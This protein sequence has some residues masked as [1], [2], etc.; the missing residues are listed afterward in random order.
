[1]TA[2]W[3][4]EVEGVKLTKIDPYDLIERIEGEWVTPNGRYTFEK[5]TGEDKRDGWEIRERGKWTAL[6]IDYTG[7]WDL[8]GRFRSL[9]HAVDVAKEHLELDR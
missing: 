9:E 8:H 4:V 3:T 5:C 7:D 6:L 1:M 2:T